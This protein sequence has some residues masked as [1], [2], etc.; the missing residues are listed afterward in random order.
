MRSGAEWDL[1]LAAN[2]PV[3]QQREIEKLRKEISQLAKS[4]QSS[5]ELLANEDFRSRA[6]QHVLENARAKMA[7]RQAEHQKLMSRLAELEKSAE[8]TN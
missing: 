2:A 5:Q 7:E 6:P 1:R 4:I 8:A 3:D